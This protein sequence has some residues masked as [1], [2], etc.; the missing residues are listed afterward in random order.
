MDVTKALEMYEAYK[1][2]WSEN[3]REARTDLQF[4]TGINQWDEADVAARK[5][6]GKVSL[7]INELPQ[8]IHQ[9]TNDIR[10]NTPSIK[11]IPE[12]DGDKDTADVFAGLIR[13]I[14]YKSGA[15]EVYD[16]AAEYAVTCGLGFIMVDHDYV[17]DEGDEQEL[18]IRRVPDPLSVFLD[19]ASVECDGRDANG[20]I[21]LEPITKKEFERQYPGKEFISFTDPKNRDVKDQIVIAQVFVREW[22][23]KRGK[24][25]TIKRYRYSGEDCLAETTFPGSYIPIVPIYGQETWIDGKRILQGLI[26]QARDPQRRLN[27]W[28]SK[29]AELLSMAPIAPV[30]AVR[31][32][33]VNDRNQWQNPGS[34]VVLEYEP[35]DLDGNPAAMPQRLAPPPIPT[36][37]INAMEGAKQNIKE[38]MGIYSASLGERSNEKSGIAIERR[39][40]EGD[41]ATFHFPDNVRRAINQV[42]RVCLDAIP[43]I[44]DTPRVIQIVNEETEPRL[45]GVNGGQPQEEQ[46]R[47]FDLTTGKYHVRVT[48]GANFTTKRQEAANFLSEMFKQA[49]ELLQIGGDILFKNLDIPGAEALASRF[50]KTMNPA[51]LEDSEQQ[52][53]Q[54]MQMQ[55]AL[56]QAQMQIQQLA[57]ELENKQGDLQLKAAEIAMKQKE[58]EVKAL[59]VQTKAQT[60]M[61]P[62]ESPMPEDNS[63]EIA[64]LTFEQQVK[65]REL[66]LKEAEFQLKVIQAQQ[67]GAELPKTDEEK[68]AEEEEA[69]MM[70]QMLE[71]EQARE[72]EEEAIK[73]QQAEMLMQ[74][75]Q[76]IGQQINQLT[77]AVQTPKR[78][79]RDESGAV[80]GVQ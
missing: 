57:A 39:Q 23:G 20:A 41:T 17:S 21:V 70:Q 73:A 42:G 12:N 68:A 50:K 9:V 4:A 13:G 49:P 60:L 77:L 56:Q 6:A 27:H 18:I 33:L 65:E 74:T 15:D 69:A 10:Q 19:P 36:G 16:T 8:F 53:P 40:Q 59:E 62:A 7:V 79:V 44:Y 11:V 26:R 71:E 54:V 66:A 45:V 75:L 52:D 14:E 76:A 61:Q 29:E 24:K 2:H 30:M 5:K 80:V 31:G 47:P 28:A 58:L 37:I 72:A 63:L 3:Y 43:T 51:L 64:K 22:G 34:E 38:S 48:T 32:T 1:T 78:V 46:Q 35:T 67:Q 55:Q 25:A